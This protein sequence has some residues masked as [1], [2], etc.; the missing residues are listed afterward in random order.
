MAGQLILADRVKETTATTGTGTYTLA[1]AAAGFDSFAEVGDGNY[2]YYCCTDGTDFEIGVGKYTASGTTLARQYVLKSSNTATATADVNGA[3]EHSYTLNVDNVSGTISPGMRIRGSSVNP[4]PQIVFTVSGTTITLLTRS[5]T[6]G[7]DTGGTFADNDSLTF[8]D[9]KVNWGS[10]SKDIFVTLPEE[11]QGGVV[12]LMY[13]DASNQFYDGGNIAIGPGAMADFIDTEYLG[14]QSVAIGINA[15]KKT[16]STTGAYPFGVAIG[17]ETAQENLTGRNM[18]AIGAFALKNDTSNNNTAVGMRAGESHTTGSNNTYVGHVSGPSQ[19]NG[20]G[21]G[22]THNVSVGVQALDHLT[23]GD[24]NVCL[25][26][27]AGT[28]I[29]TGSQSVHIG[30]RAGDYVTTAND[31]IGIGYSAGAE[32]GTYSVS[33]GYQANSSTSQNQ[34]GLGNICIGYQTGDAITSGDYN[35]LMGYATDMPRGYYSRSVAIGYYADCNGDD[36]VNIGTN[37]GSAVSSGY[38]D[39]DNNVAIGS[40]AH[41][42]NGSGDNNINIGVNTSRAYYTTSG[43]NISIGYQASYYLNGAQW[44]TN[45]GSQAG[46][47]DQNSYGSTRIGYRAGRYYTGSYGTILGYQAGFTGTTTYSGNG[48]IAIGFNAVPSSTTASYEITLG[49]STISSLR[50]QVTS[51]TALSDERDKTAIEDTDLGLDFIKALRPVNFTWNRRD[52]TWPGRKEVGFIAQ[53]LHEVEMNFNSTNRTRLVSYSNPEKLEATP[54]NTYPIL[55]KAVQ[56]LS[57]KVESLQ[58]RITKLEGS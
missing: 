11:S 12:D 15:L 40:Y 13:S 52:G 41:Y 37:A 45:I 18:T 24:Y 21:D 50:C 44:S 8:T 16:S 17:F 4:L 26:N 10:G 28:D 25:G 39:G 57:A 36:C 22:A 53:E 6:T 35:I 38:T 56:E 30:R 20:T 2:C 54:M 48:I 42:G 5:N 7:D 3:V 32:S 51:I 47:Q 55:V 43:E 34:G 46:Q 33:I 31:T 9:G 58:A 19:E 14:G 49:N 27:Q 23:S 29:T 1:G